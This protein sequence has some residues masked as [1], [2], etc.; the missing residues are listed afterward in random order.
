MGVRSMSPEDLYM[1]RRRLGLTQAQLAESWGV[2]ASLVTSI[3]LGRRRFT[4]RRQREVT[5]I[6]DGRFVQNFVPAE[7]PT[8]PQVPRRRTLAADRHAMAAGTR[9]LVGRAERFVQTNPSRVSPAVARNSIA[10]S[11]LKPA[12]AVRAGPIHPEF[13]RCEW[14]DQKGR[15]GGTTPPDMRYCAQHM[16]LAM[17][18][19]MPTRR[20]G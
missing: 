14:R 16:A 17:I 20:R 18:Q 1:L 8:N 6:F 10:V 2:S 15:C 7:P 4:K 3:E 19:G 12:P 9:M 11:V 5:Q 13:V